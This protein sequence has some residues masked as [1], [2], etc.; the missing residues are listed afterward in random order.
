M[1]TFANAVNPSLN[2]RLPYDAH[3]DFAAVALIARSFN[4][5]V[6]SSASPIK[7]IADLIAVAKVDSNKLSYGTTAPAHQRIWRV[8]CSRAWPRSI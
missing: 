4:I 1:G 3:K 7:S 6:V 2:S 8:N 5:V